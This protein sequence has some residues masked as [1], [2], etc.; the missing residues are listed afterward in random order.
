[1]YLSYLV[2]DLIWIN[3][4]YIINQVHLTTWHI[5]SSGFPIVSCWQTCYWL[6]PAMVCADKKNTFS[7][8]DHISNQQR[9][10]DL[11]GVIT[12]KGTRT[13]QW[14]QQ[15]WAKAS[16]LVPPYI[17]M[18]WF[19]TA[20]SL[21]DAYCLLQLTRE[22][23]SGYRPG[24]EP[25][26]HRPALVPCMAPLWDNLGTQHGNGKE[27]KRDK[28]KMAASQIYERMLDGRREGSKG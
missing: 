11:M 18:N 5:M 4:H 21:A 15:P 22:G 16:P 8:L 28:R 1:M 14:Q 12:N 17:S 13:L 27:D 24:P 26:Q 3:H 20:S 6:I 9:S 7:F 25:V 10:S 2:M 19:C 23:Y